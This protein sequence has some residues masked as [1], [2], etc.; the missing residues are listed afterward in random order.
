MSQRS[1]S[2]I[3]GM[4]S[5]CEIGE[6]AVGGKAWN[7]FR[8]LSLGFPVPPFFVVS[9]SAFEEALMSRQPEIR[10]RLKTLETQSVD[11][12]ER[13]SQRLIDFVAGVQFPEE[14]RCEIKEVAAGSFGRGKRF[15]VRSSI[16]GEDGVRNSFA[17]QMDSFLDVP[18]IRIFEAIK[19]VWASAFSPRALLYRREKRVRGDGIAA[20]VIIQEMVPAASSGILF[21]RDPDSRRRE[22]IISAGFGLG[23]GVVSNRIESDTYKIGW[24]GEAIAKEVALKDYRVMGKTQAQGGTAVERVPEKLKSAPVLTEARVQALRDIGIK[25]ERLFGLPLDI[26]WAFDSRGKLFVLQ[27]R[28]I[29]FAEESPPA[30]IRRLWDNSNIVESYPGVTLPLTFSFVRRCYEIIFRDAASKLTLAKKAIEQ[31]PDI[32]PSMIGLIGG[33]VY[34]NLLNWYTMQ[35]CFPGFNKYKD[36]WDRMIGISENTPF[37]RRRFS[38]IHALSSTLKM[39]WIMLAVK[40]TARKFFR[41]FDRAYSKFKDTDFARTSECE[42]LALY[43]AI[44][45]EFSRR[46]YLTL[47]NDFCAIKYYDWLRTLMAK[48]ITKETNNLHNS[49]LCGVRGMESVAPVRSLARLA[50]TVNSKPE[51]RNLFVRNDDP[52]IWAAI[53]H[54]PDLAPMKAGLTA[55]LEAYGDR[56]LEELKLEK[57]TFREEP[58]QLIRLIRD[59][60]NSG[61]IPEFAD[62]KDQKIRRE[63]EA[64]VKKRL[65]NPLKRLALG[66]VL[67]NARRA[68]AQRENMRFART[69]LFGI[70]RRLF[71]RLGRLLEEKGFIESA[72]DIHY[73]TAEEVLGLIQGTAVTQ[74]LQGLAALRK[75]EYRGHAQ[76]SP[77]ARF[78]TTGIPYL[79]SAYEDKA[80]PGRYKRLKGI[81]CSSGIARG[82]AKVV[83]DPRLARGNGNSILVAQSTD[84]GWVFLMI[85]AKGIV[86]E[87]GSVL[88]HTAIIGRELGIPTIVGVKDAT[89]LIPDGASM[90]IDGGTGDVQ[91]Q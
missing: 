85:S 34:Y 21:T 26:E 54:N 87:R 24:L 5:L 78:E 28:P 40:R 29:V 47:Y 91:W 65:R 66:F 36:S 77:R 22:C 39:S 88:S 52:K 30:T 8:L 86:T 46:W 70:I 2:I 19:K 89:R 51:Y 44:E 83:T 4:T 15:A 35:S 16:V 81:S 74:N 17:G 80:G 50:E 90:C 84:P 14:L 41:S 57:P 9:T 76:K 31:R 55:Y 53:Q 23:E 69:R 75:A 64:E 62:R 20:A 38:F 72:S 12:I 13:F 7:L 60:L 56:T 82:T 68:V 49:L 32:F 18:E 63:A 10:D 71:S 79:H 67:K 37:S 25:A 45:R 43:E 59:F 27:A 1:K 11:E 6:R 33:R 48:W 42:L 58:S 3:S 61:L 73:L